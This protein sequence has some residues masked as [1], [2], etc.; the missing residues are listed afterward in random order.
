MKPTSAI[1]AAEPTWE[2]AHLFPRQGAWSEEEYL[3]LETNHL[4]EFS[5]GYIEVLPMP[6]EAHQLIVAYLYGQLLAFVRRHRPG[7]TVLFAPLPV[8]LWA[9][10]YREPDVILML[11]EHAD[12]R[13]QHYWEVPDLVMEVVSPDYRRHDLE[14]KRREY[15]QAGITEYWIVDPEEE[16][17]TVLTLEGEEYAVHGVFERGMVARSALLAGFE[18]AVDE[19]WAAAA[20]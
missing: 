3:S 5:H 20:Q 4:V 19:V 16:Q 1:E 13:H 12:R 17:I 14:T 9:G 2:I 18:V 7:A 15:A 8:Q 11:A 10:K 6:T